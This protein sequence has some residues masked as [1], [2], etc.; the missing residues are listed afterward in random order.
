MEGCDRRAASNRDSPERGQV[1]VAELTDVDPP[2]VAIG[3]NVGMT[4]RR[5]YTA[6]SVH[7]YFWKAFLIIWR[8]VG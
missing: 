4:F 6:Q 5:L 8:L 1:Q 7:N 3:N 2:T